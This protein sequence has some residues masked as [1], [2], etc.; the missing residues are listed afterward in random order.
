TDVAGIHEYD[1][2]GREVW[3]YTQGGQGA[4]I[5]RKLASGNVL[6]ADPNTNA[7]YEVRPLGR[8]GGDVP[9]RMEEVQYPRD[10]SRLDNGNTLVAEQY[11]RR[12]VEYDSK[13]RQVV[14]QHQTEYPLTAQRL[15]NGNTL[16][17]TQSAV[18]E[19]N[20]AS[21]VQWSADL[22][23]TVIRPFRASR[24]D[25]GNTL[26]VDQQKGQVLE[27]DARSTIVW[28][29]SGFSM[30]SQAIRL[31]DGNTLILE[32]GANRIVEVDPINPKIRTELN[33]RGLNQ[34][35]GMS[36]Y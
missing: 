1:P 8:T 23:T 6:V 9:W 22:R 11:N 13:T 18:L 28:K 14:W 20:R 3:S 21:A 19:V 32:T 5:A 7:L 31:E 30:P 27:L 35:Q 25:N 16:I 24:L 34:P 10:A 36:T 2:R 4:S 29:A 15:D 12:V 26:I 17:C 33:I